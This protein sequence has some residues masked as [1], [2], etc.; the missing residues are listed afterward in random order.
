MAA[1]EKL[2]AGPL[3]ELLKRGRDRYNTKFA[4][5][6]RQ[7]ASL[8]GEAFLDHVRVTLAPIAEAVSK[9]A[10][11]R[12]EETIDALYDLSL[13]LMGKTY[14]GETTRYPA[15]LVAWRKLLPQLAPLLAREPMKVASAVTNAVYNLS[16]TPTARPTFWIDAMAALG[17][18]CVDRAAFLEA[19]H[20]VA[21]RAGVAHYRE[22]ALDS[23]LKLD[24]QL[25]R[26]ALGLPDSSATSMAKVVDQLRR[27]PWLAPAEASG[28]ATR[29]RRLVITKAVGAFRGFGGVFVSPP[30][31]ALAKGEL[32]AVDR[33][34]CWL[35]TADL[36]GATFHRLGSARPLEKKSIS[37]AFMIDKQGNVSCGSQSLAF[38]PLANATS[39]AA[40]DTTLAVTI[41]HSHAIYLIALAT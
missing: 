5:A 25:A 28:T 7:H 21:W 4:Y 10:P 40:T 23:C 33:E 15:L 3:V 29:A 19:G 2:T 8:D 31:V 12:V 38:P 27:D 9:V 30:Q 17:Q 24:G 35:V 26:A 14:L 11:D 37:G 34:G 32:I 41:P 39:F 18:R 6:R 36:F 22:G 16:T 1:M 20:V 13:D